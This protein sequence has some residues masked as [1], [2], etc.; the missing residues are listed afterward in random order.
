MIIM[1]VYD[2]VTFALTIQELLQI[3]IKNE[4]RHVIFQEN[5]ENKRTEITNFIRIKLFLME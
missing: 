3:Q 4:I 5:V 2:N 1:C